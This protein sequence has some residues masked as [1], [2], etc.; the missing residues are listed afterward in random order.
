[1]REIEEETRNIGLQISKIMLSGTN[2][3]KSK[4]KAMKARIDRLNAE[5]AF[6]MTENNFTIDYMDL[7]YDCPLCKDTGTLDT[8]GRCS[9]FAEKLKNIQKTD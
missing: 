4:I 9:C 6:L 2:D 1:M 7:T 5:K 8:G 3:V